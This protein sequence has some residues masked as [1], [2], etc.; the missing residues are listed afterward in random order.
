[1]ASISLSDE[2]TKELRTLLSTIHI[3]ERTGEIGVLHGLDR[4]VS[5]NVCKK[6]KEI[7][8]LDAVARRCGLS[9]IRRFAK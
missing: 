5:T 7:E 6:K 4:F 2:E 8:A 9:G 3:R 1:M